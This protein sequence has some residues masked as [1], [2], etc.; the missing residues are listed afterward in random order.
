MI[1]D[2]IKKCSAKTFL[3]QSK[4]PLIFDKY[5]PLPNNVILGT[6]VE[7]DNTVLAGTVSKAPNTMLRCSA[8]AILNHPRK[9]VTIEPIMK[10][11][12]TVLSLW[13]KV[14]GPEFVYIGFDSVG[15]SFPQPDPRKAMELVNRLR[16]Y[17]IEV[18][19]K[20]LSGNLFNY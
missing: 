6:T 11:N 3:L 20:K 1:I 5:L 16:C 17:G 7:T 8:L 9:M 18:I 19:V 15:S 2:R 12:L 13:I 14:I 10:F 4:N